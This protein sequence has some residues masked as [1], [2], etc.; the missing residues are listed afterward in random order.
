[1]NPTASNIDVLRTMARH[2]PVAAGDIV[3]SAAELERAMSVAV[4]RGQAEPH[5]ARRVR[6]RFT[7]ALGIGASVA[8][9]AV[10]AAVILLTGG[11]SVTSPEQPT[12][13]AAA[14]KVAKSNPRL[15]VTAPGWEITSAYKFEPTDGELKF[16]DGEHSI[17]MTWYP[18]RLY[19]QYL[20]DRADVSPP[21][22]STVLGHTATTT[23]YGPGGGYE[24]LLSPDGGRIFIG[25]RAFV[26][27]HAT[28]DAI[29]ESLRSVDVDTWLAAMP[30][31]VVQP[32]ERPAVVDHIL[33]GIP[34]PPGFHANAVRNGASVGDEHSMAINLTRT[35]ACDWLDSWVAATKAGNQKAAQAAVDAMATS[36]DWPVFHGLGRGTPAR[37]IWEFADQIARGHLDTGF[38]VNLVEADGTKYAFGP[39]YARDLGCDSMRRRKVN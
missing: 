8:C 32:A 12:Y 29:L 9:A 4:H 35:I 2:N 13:A 28:D 3:V 17:E 22:R 10:V 23:Y 31:S 38:T 27:D 24:T 30:P 33:R 21:E 26:D 7:T 15:L 25:L 1:M 5:R 20:T 34:L 39:G 19:G 11:G 18:A 16:S 36:R 6:P 14:V 37:A